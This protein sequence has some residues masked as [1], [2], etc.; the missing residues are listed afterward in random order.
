MTTGEN[1]AFRE[2][3][4]LARVFGRVADH[5]VA[6]YASTYDLN[7]GRTRFTDWLHEQTVP[8]PASSRAADAGAGGASLSVGSLTAGNLAVAIKTGAEAI[9][10]PFRPMSDELVAHAD[11]A[12]TQ[13]YGNH[14]RSLVRLAGLLVRDEPTAELVVQDCFIAMHS[15]WHRLRDED[16]A[17][18]YLKQAVVNRAR[19]VLRERSRAD[20]NAP[21][22]APDLPAVEQGAITMLERSAVIAALRALPDRQRQT[23]V[24][25]YYADL[26]ETQIAEMMGISRSA[27]KSHTARGMASLR[28]VLE[29]TS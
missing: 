11:E 25:R 21:R 5:Q 9:E 1:D 23:L 10:V 19:S 6:R 18:S 2:D 8:E 22:S 4:D 13:L 16:K 27:V 12:V 7:T 14:Y 20:R 3:E 17:L 24:L 15:G 29:Q 26:S 28:A